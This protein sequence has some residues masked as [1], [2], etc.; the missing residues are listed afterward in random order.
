M[1]SA[2][3][4]LFV[5]FVFTDVVQPAILAPLVSSTTCVCACV[6]VCVTEVP[7]GFQVLKVSDVAAWIEWAN[8]EQMCS[9][10]ELDCKEEFNKNQT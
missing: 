7:N 1:T 3:P 6:C 2:V 4:S 5:F 8:R 10:T 9:I